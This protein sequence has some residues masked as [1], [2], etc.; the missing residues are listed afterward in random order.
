MAPS[1]SARC[2]YFRDY[3]D[4]EIRGDQNEG[5]SVFRPA[6]GLAVYN[7]TQRRPFVLPDTAFESGANVGEIFVFCMSK[8]FAELQRER[9][10]AAACVE[11]LDARAFCHRV[12]KALPRRAAFPGR[13][14]HTRIGQHVC[15]IAPVT[16]AI[17]V[18]HCPI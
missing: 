17:H 2:A 15:T 9:F 12:Q 11:I 3:E 7:R 14:E 5:N 6:N 4:A 13:P 18:G 1:C 8:S 10:R 16:A